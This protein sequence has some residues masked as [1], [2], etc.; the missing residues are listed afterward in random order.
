V[1]KPSVAVMVPFRQ[2]RNLMLVS[3]KQKQHQP[4]QQQQQQQQQQQ[5][6]CIK[7]KHLQQQHR[8]S[9]PQE[10]KSSSN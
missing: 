3:T 10:P 1:R 9:E 2:A 7:Q 4:W 5:L 6:A 8:P